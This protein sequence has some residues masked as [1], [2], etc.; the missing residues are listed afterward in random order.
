[1]PGP[2]PAPRFPLHL[3]PERFAVC[4][5][6]PGAPR[7]TW[8]DGGDEPGGLACVVR[9]PEELS[10]VCR[11]ALVPDGVRCERGWRALRLQGPIPF[12]VTGVVAGLT[13]PLAA[14]GVGVFVVSTFDTD[15]LLVPAARLETALAAWQAAGQDVRGAAPAATGTH[16]PE[17][18]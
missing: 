3:L 14:A 13:A 16:A 8:A 2:S 10:I 7:P 4:R 9:T 11:E 18:L 17:S 15:Y 12:G 5:L 1:M 6:P